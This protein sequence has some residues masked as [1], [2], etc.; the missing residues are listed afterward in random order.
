MSPFSIDLF[1]NRGNGWIKGRR[2]ERRLEKSRD[3]VPCTKKR[4]KEKG[5]KAVR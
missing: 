2:K 4:K 3:Y 5:E 1:R